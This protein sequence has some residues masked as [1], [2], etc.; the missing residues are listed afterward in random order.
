MN[1]QHRDILTAIGRKQPITTSG[2]AEYLMDHFGYGGG[3]EFDAFRDQVSKAI[4]YLKSKGKLTGEDCTQ[5][6]GKPL[7]YW[8][9]AK[10]EE[11]A[12][13]VVEVQATD[14]LKW[15]ELKVETMKAH[16][17]SVPETVTPEPT[18]SVEVKASKK[19]PINIPQA[20]KHFYEYELEEKDM[21]AFMEGIRFAEEHHGISQ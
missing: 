13:D 6:K 10:A 7:R 4:G 5:P 14:E 11:M 3:M 16:V 9:L 12:S 1:T 20:L 17:E 2:V 21:P 19:I 8:S 15:E 18:I